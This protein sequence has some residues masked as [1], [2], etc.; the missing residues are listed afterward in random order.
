M[1]R[2]RK[3]AG[4][5]LTK[6]TGVPQAPAAGRKAS[7]V[8]NEVPQLWISLFTDPAVWK[9]I[10]GLTGRLSWAR[11]GKL[12]NASSQGKKQRSLKK[13]GRSWGPLGWFWCSS[14]R[15]GCSVFPHPPSPTIMKWTQTSVSPRPILLLFTLWPTFGKNKNGKPLKNAVT[16]RPES[17]LLGLESGSWK[18]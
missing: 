15:L 5:G 12:E 13:T 9:T 18:R 8:T 3:T 1:S 10:I 4:R 11:W 2:N 6:Q 14:G 7:A 16:E 17:L